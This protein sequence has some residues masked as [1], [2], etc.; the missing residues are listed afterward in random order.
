MASAARRRNAVQ[1]AFPGIPFPDDLFAFRD[2]L[3]KHP[4]AAGTLEVTT[5][6]PLAMLEGATSRID[7]FFDD[8]PEFITVLVGHSDGLHWGY[9]FDAPG[10]LE[11]VVASFSANDAFEIGTS[12]VTLFEAM[13]EHLEAL[14]Q[15]AEAAASDE[16][17]HAAVHRERVD[18][19]AAVRAAF[20]KHAPDLRRRRETGE[21]YFGK[22]VF[23]TKPRTHRRP[24][25]PTRSSMG[26]VVEKKQYRALGLK[27]ADVTRL[28][29]AA[30]AAAEAGA[31]GAALQ[32]G[33]DLWTDRE[34]R[35]TSSELLDLAYSK[36]DRS[37]LRALLSKAMAFRERAEGAGKKRRSR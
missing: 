29:K 9:W 30:R 2:F 37:P 26:I 18:A 22:Y 31:P 4:D 32:L 7:R 17:E 20:A 10:K 11:P 14:H 6:G 15:E 1:Q 5:A 13:R 8:P 12:G 33:H 21:A 35:V 23:S 27:S 3:A 25:A 24:V 34:H 16:P 28:E 19:L 36:L